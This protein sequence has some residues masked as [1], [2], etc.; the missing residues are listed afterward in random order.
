M[1]NYDESKTVNEIS[2]QNSIIQ[3]VVK[4]REHVEKLHGVDD[5]LTT[6]CLLFQIITDLK[7]IIAHLEIGTG[8]E[9]TDEDIEKFDEE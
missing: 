2:L 4:V 3:S 7:V 6:Q 5:S 1:F 8:E 9:I